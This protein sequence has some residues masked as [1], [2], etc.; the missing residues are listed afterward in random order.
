MDEDDQERESSSIEIT[1][2]DFDESEKMAEVKRIFASKEGTEGAVS[3][4][5]LQSY[6]SQDGDK[7]VEAVAAWLS[8]N[9][10]I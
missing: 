2:S 8:G 5:E 1:M 10:E 3:I 9:D 7:C 4:D 6:V